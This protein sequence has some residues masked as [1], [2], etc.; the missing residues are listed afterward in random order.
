MDMSIGDA[1]CVMDR[2]G[3]IVWANN[4][5][6]ELF[7]HRITP[8]GTMFNQLFSGIVDVCRHGE[9]L[10]DRDRTGQKR[11]FKAECR[12]LNNARGDHVSDVVVLR[13]VTLM[14]TMSNISRLSTQTRTP[15]EFF[16]KA[17][18]IV[19]ETYGYL[20]LAGFVARDGTI[21]LEASKGWTEKLKSMIRIVP[22]APDAPSM[23]GRCA[24]H[25]RQ[26]VTTIE[27]YGLMPTV[28]EAI[29]RIGG[30]FVVVTPL[31]DHDRLTGV[32]TVI[33][34]K[35][36]SPAELDMLQS[37]CGQIAVSLN[38]RLQEEELSG[39]A[40]ESALFVDLIGHV[41]G[42]NDKVLA[43]TQEQAETT[44]TILSTDAA[45]ALKSNA[46][47]IKTIQLHSKRDVGVI[48]T[49]P[50]SEAV[51]ASTE[52]TGMIARL[53]DRKV[54]VSY[55]KPQTE[56]RTGPLF[57]YALRMIIASSIMHSPADSL[58]IDI[59]ASKDR[60][61]TYK[62]DVSDN[63]PGIPDERKSE[64]LRQNG[65]K[66]GAIDLSLV[67]RIVNYYGGRVWI[68][69]RVPGNSARGAR[70]VITLPE[71]NKD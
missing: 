41:I 27:E 26:M 4:T 54:N 60:L 46:E 21:E 34:S 64:V 11:H 65:Q 20:G 3:M 22:V 40:D 45:T 35:A 13:N 8:V 31:I 28:K 18:W 61:G 51:R 16:E 7:S 14:V 44:P 67:K 50:L 12:R 32:L 33:H 43:A 49:M 6:I 69:D 58:N 39:K 42:E 38:V 53:Y 47:I 24:Y 71:S 68:E 55:K 57:Q 66:E 19:K 62:I 17:L 37:V 30:E 25:R 56:P 36:L 5:F 63:G 23:A 10:E 29:E 15:K 9:V 52:E 70:V 59:K 1:S 48:A 2:Y